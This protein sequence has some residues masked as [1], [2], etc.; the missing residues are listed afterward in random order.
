MNPRIKTVHKD[1]LNIIPESIYSY[2]LHDASQHYI[3]QH[4]LA[5][6]GNLN[7]IYKTSIQEIGQKIIHPED[8][9]IVAD[10]FKFI[11]ENCVVTFSSKPVVIF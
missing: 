2:H 7:K 4:T 11:E 6:L 8:L 10:G 3:N 5:I 1:V 9:H